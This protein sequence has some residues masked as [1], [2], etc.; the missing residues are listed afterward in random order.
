MDEEDWDGWLMLT[1]RIGGTVQ[2][3]GDDLFVTNTERLRGLQRGAA[4]AQL[5]VLV[6]EPLDLRLLGLRVLPGRP[7]A[8]DRPDVEVHEEQQDQQ[9]R[10]APHAVPPD[11]GSDVG[12]H[13]GSSPP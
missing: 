13:G 2:L 8:A 3:V 11:A 6:L 9:E 4:S 1:E 12:H 7:P 10:D 5:G